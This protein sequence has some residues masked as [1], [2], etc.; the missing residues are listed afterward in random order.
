MRGS[1]AQLIWI[2]PRLTL[3]CR[4]P[5]VYSDSNRRE[6]APPP[7]LRTLLKITGTEAGATEEPAPCILS[8]V[9]I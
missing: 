6:G 1:S 3:S 9:I 4:S 8:D 7:V 5:I 2:S